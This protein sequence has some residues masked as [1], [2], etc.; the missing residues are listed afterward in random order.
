MTDNFYRQL[1]R[2]SKQPTGMLAF[3]ARSLGHHRISPGW[4]DF[5]NP[6][7]F[8]EFFWS[9]AGTGSIVLKGQKHRLPPGSVALYFP[10]ETHEVSTDG[11][12]AWE[13]RWWTMDGALAAPM[14]KSLGF[15]GNTTYN[16]GP[17]P[18]SLFQQLSEHISDV[19]HAGEVRAAATAFELVSSIA[20]IT[21]P[22]E[23]TPQQRTRSDQSF[24]T[25]ALDCVQSSWTDP[26]FGVSQMADALGLHRSV[27]SRRF[28]L[29]F[30]L[31]PSD[32]LNRWRVQ[33]ALTLL[34]ETN[35]PIHDIARSCGWDDPNYF[36]RCIRKVTGRPPR[37]IRRA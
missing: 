33:N 2:P 15:S 8:V 37:S 4:Q 24:R 31:S 28:Y 6:K 36:A 22:H 13:Y 12:G 23:E 32:Y 10:N 3:G 25:A 1:F 21:R 14:I 7:P 26:G 18:L 30:G 17:P 29:E 16:V 11:P 34:S 5:P 9:V 19:T 20:A 27:L 35:R